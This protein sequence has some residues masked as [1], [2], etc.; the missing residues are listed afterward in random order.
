DSTAPPSVRIITTFDRLVNQAAIM[1]SPLLANYAAYQTKGRIMKFRLIPRRRLTRLLLVPLLATA[2]G[3]ATAIPSQADTHIV[4]AA[5]GD[6]Y[7]SGVGA[8]PYDPGSLAC[9]QSP[10]SAAKLWAD[11]HGAKFTFAACNGATTT[12]VINNQVDKVDPHTTH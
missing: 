5:L 1:L 9:E 11:Q 4:Y 7:A 3:T 12:N 8:P 2:V 6:S 10:Q